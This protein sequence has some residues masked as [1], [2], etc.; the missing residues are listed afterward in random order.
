MAVEGK[1]VDMEHTVGKNH[2]VSKR[3]A[4]EVA[5]LLGFWWKNVCSCVFCRGAAAKQTL[6]A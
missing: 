3:L 1:W 6:T 5:N 4:N 2:A